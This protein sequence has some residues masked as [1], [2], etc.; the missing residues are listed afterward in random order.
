[1]TDTNNTL[2]SVTDIH[3]SFGKLKAL[4][5]VDMEVEAGSITGLIGPNGSGKTTLF[6]VVTGFYKKDRGHGKIIFQGTQIDG[7]DPAQIAD[8]GIQ[9]TFQISQ[10]TRKM[11]VMENL[12]L[13]SKQQPG[14]SIFN[15]FFRPRLLINTEQDQLRKAHE[16]LETIQLE[17]L[18]D[19]FAGNLSGG[20]KKLLALGRMLMAD[21]ELMMLD[22]PTAGVN[23]TLT[24]D[25]LEIIQ[26][27]RQDTGKTYFL[28]EHSMKVISSLCDYVYVLDFGENLTAGT[29]EEVQSDEKVLE[30]YL[31]GQTS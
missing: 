7:M 19:E 6:N 11:T 23:P 31:T 29:P 4:N 16:I 5:G 28:I 20:Q 27:L 1:M 9:R 3:K 13:A 18:M 12:L 30:A 24:N 14:E 25:L 2:L 8:E 10:A 26:K 15:S 22:E 21:P 17:D